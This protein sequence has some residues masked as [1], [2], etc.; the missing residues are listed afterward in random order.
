MEAPALAD[1]P[2]VGINGSVPMIM[3][4][5][6]DT[7]T[8]SLAIEYAKKGIRNNAAASGADDAPF[9]KNDPK[10]FSKGSQPI[11]KFVSIKDVADAALYLVKAVQVTGEVLHVKTVVLRHEPTR[12]YDSILSFHDMLCTVE[13][14]TWQLIADE[15]SVSEIL[16]TARTADFDPDVGPGY[17]NG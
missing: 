10:D 8:K 12:N 1:R 11:G 5:S 14:R 15:A 3:K 17:V 9:H 13:Q 4:G 16:A 7:V 6:L 2:I